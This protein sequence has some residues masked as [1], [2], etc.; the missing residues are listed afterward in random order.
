MQASRIALLSGLIAASCL[1]KGMDIDP[2]LDGDAGGSGAHAT[3]AGSSASGSPGSGGS[4]GAGKANGEAAA[5]AGDESGGDSGSPT[6]GGAAAGGSGSSGMSGDG[7]SQV[8]GSGGSAMAGSGG[9]AGSGGTDAD[10]STGCNAPP[11]LSSGSKT[12]MSSDLERSYVLDIPANYAQATPNELVIAWH[13]VGS[14]A[15]QIAA[16]TGEVS[17]VGAFYGLKA[18]AAE[19]SIFVAP[20]TYDGTWAQNAALELQFARD[21]VT[22]LEAKLC[23]DLGRIFSVG[24][25]VGGAMSVAVGCS[26]GDVFRATAAINGNT[27]FVGCAAG[28]TPIAYWAAHGSSATPSGNT[29]RDT[30]VTRNGCE[31]TTVAADDPCVLYQGCEPGYPVQWCPF[32]GSDMIP[33]FA[34]ASISTFF[35][36]F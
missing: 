17:A 25:S 11:G 31:T 2:A 13:P 19:G 23:I 26:M 7:G 29:A 16:G 10:P 28:A 4:S 21:L 33:P 3:Q 15:A 6:N 24:W 34:P 14:T 35:S 8:S 18:L 27:T 30:F 22:E 12:L 1:V 32:T 5:G 9:S 20:Q 36:Q